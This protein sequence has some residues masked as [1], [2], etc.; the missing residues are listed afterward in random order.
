MQKRSKIIIGICC[1]GL[2]VG[3][4]C[5]YQTMTVITPISVMEL[6]ARN[7]TLPEVPTIAVY[8]DKIV[9]TTDITQPKDLFIGDCS[10]R[11]GI[12]NR[13]DSGCASEEKNCVITCALTCTLPTE[14]E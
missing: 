13:C 6:P 7:A 12:F 10:M 2:I 11:G 14:T 1:L 8:K 4:I 9:Y 3:G 5:L